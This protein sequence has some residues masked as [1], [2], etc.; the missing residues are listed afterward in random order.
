M[1]CPRCETELKVE[2]SESPK[3]LQEGD[4]V[5]CF[6]IA[7]NLNVRLGDYGEVTK[8]V[9]R[10]N[11]SVNWPTGA[12]D[13]PVGYIRKIKPPTLAIGDRV[14]AVISGQKWNCSIAAGD[15]GKVI[16]TGG[17]EHVGVEWENN[18]RYYFPNKYLIVIPFWDPSHGRIQ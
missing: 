12:H 2:I 17:G 6:R 14:K 11:I 15:V 8:V 4:V 1:K 10:E 7:P 16:E 9:N 5:V 3:G 18:L 13:C